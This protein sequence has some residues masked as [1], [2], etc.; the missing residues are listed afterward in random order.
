M[1]QAILN[2]FYVDDLLQSTRDIT[3]ARDIIVDTAAV[4]KHGGFRLTKFVVN[5]SEL[6]NDIDESDRATVVK[7]MMPEMMSKALGVRW[8]ICGDTFSYVCK[9]KSPIGPVTR[10][11]MLSFVSTMYDPRGLISAIVLKGKL[12]FQEAMRLKLSWDT[13]VP[14]SLSYAWLEWLKSLN[15]LETLKFTRC[16]VPDAFTDGV[17]EI[18]NFCDGS[19]VGF[20]CCSYIRVINKVGKVHVCLVA[21][22]SRLAP[23]KR[24]TVP[25]L[26][27]A[28][29]FKL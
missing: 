25:R 12:L 2:N 11:T 13:P 1:K 19:Q 16:M 9:Q 6:L 17:A 28:S 4:L 24:V 23:L 5:C 10:R 22:K 3:E 14:E 7:D 8:E 26:E 21:A 27:L 18:H 20:G 15:D 29:A